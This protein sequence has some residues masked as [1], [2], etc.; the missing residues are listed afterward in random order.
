MIRLPPRSTLSSSSAASDVY[1][2]QELDIHVSAIASQ[3]E[4]SGID[5]RASVLLNVS[6]ESEMLPEPIEPE[7]E[8]ETTPESETASE[9]ESESESVPEQTTVIVDEPGSDANASESAADSAARSGGMF[10]YAASIALFV[11]LIV[12]IRRWIK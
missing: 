6:G 11:F 2:R 10:S 8:T 7:T 12:S 1:K 3:T 9:S 5:N 4:I